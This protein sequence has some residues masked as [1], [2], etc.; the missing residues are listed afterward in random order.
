MNRLFK[1]PKM[2]SINAAVDILIWLRK[3]QQRRRRSFVEPF[4]SP[5]QQEQHE[6]KL[7]KYLNFI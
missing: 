5:N 7:N 4:L 2:C 6:N 1:Y 3:K